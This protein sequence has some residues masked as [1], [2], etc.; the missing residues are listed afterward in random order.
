MSTTAGD[1][2]R[3]T[4]G[5]GSTIPTADDS[6]LA[7]ITAEELGA[8]DDAEADLFIGGRGD[9]ARDSDEDGAALVDRETGEIMDGLDPG[10]VRDAASELV[11]TTTAGSGEATATTF[12]EVAETVDNVGG[13][14]P[15]LPSLP[16]VGGSGGIGMGLIAAVV[17]LVVLV[18]G[19]SDSGE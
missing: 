15:M 18:V 8:L 11:E 1:L 2:F 6:E 4:D 3:G 7:D 13:G 19:T 5:S 9:A 12:D 14:G 17:G 10:A 16:A